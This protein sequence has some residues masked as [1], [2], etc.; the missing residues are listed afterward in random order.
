LKV[1]HIL[2]AGGEG[3]RCIYFQ[4]EGVALPTISPY[5][6]FEMDHLPNGQIF[7]II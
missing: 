6:P 4:G 2:G 5:T 3:S 7:S 1:K